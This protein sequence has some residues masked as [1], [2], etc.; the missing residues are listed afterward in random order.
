MNIEEV[1]KLARLKLNEDEKEKFEP[2]FKDIIN[3]INELNQLD[4]S[5]I[6]GTF[7]I[8]SMET[9]MRNDEEKK[10]ENIESIKNNFTNREYDFLKVKKV[11]E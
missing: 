1:A 3:W 4:T 11:I 6:E 10:F 2:Q 8:T 5:Q 9:R 7:S